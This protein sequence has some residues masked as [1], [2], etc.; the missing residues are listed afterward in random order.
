[1]GYGIVRRTKYSKL[2]NHPC[3]MFITL[4]TSN[5]T[6]RPISKCWDNILKAI[7]RKYPNFEYLKLI[8]DEGVNGT[9][10]IIARNS[11]FIAKAWLSEKASVSFQASVSWSTQCYGN[12]H[13]LAN[14]LLGY[15][16]H[17]E[18][19][20]FFSSRNWIFPNWNRRFKMVFSMTSE[21]SFQDKIVKWNKVLNSDYG[22][23]IRKVGK[24]EVLPFY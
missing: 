11:E 14:Y 15:L 8:C 9:I 23:V 21:L 13:S 6:E 22:L 16:K 4:T 20:L 19:Y 2:S 12:I 18:L 7:R 10:H 3:L 24:N 1:M 17:H 5:Q